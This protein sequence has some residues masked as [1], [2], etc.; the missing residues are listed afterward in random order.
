[1][2]SWLDL[3]ATGPKFDIR[4]LGPVHECICGSS[5]FNVTCSFED[6]EISMYLLE[7]TCKL[8]GSYVIVPTPVDE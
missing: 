7:A 1:M 4:S 8:C 2:K 5:L 6:G 3:E